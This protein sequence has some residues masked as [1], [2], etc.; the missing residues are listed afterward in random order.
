MDRRVSFPI[1][2]IIAITFSSLT[3]FLF[4]RPF[5][6]D[7]H[8]HHPQCSHLRLYFLVTLCFRTVLTRLAIRLLL[9]VLGP[10]LNQTAC[11]CLLHWLLTLTKI[12]A[13]PKLILVCTPKGLGQ[14]FQLLPRYVPCH[15][16]CVYLDCLK[17]LGQS[18]PGSY[19]ATTT[20]D[21]FTYLSQ[22][23]MR[24]RQNN[25]LVNSE[26]QIWK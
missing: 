2:K 15:S 11:A 26:L 20:Y 3:V 4:P 16:F 25:D 22:E 23:C 7:H 1:D 5:S 18:Q 24:L 10:F 21:P 12:L 9:L 13:L 17:H 19:A 8:H 14:C 6:L